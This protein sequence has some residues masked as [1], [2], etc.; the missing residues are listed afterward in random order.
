MLDLM[1]MTGLPEGAPR[2]G[3]GPWTGRRAAGKVRFSDRFERMDQPLEQGGQWRRVTGRGLGMI[4][5]SRLVFPRPAV[6]LMLSVRGAVIGA[7]QFIEVR[8]G[9]MGGANSHLTLHVR[10]SGLGANYYRAFFC[11]DGSCGLDARIEGANS[12]LGGMRDCRL[13]AGD[14]VR[15]EVREDCLQ[16]RINGLLHHRRIDGRL[17]AGRPGLGAHGARGMSGLALCGVTA[18]DVA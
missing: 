16:V 14:I 18:G 1:Q 5:Q 11:G 15:F 3:V 9:A 7:D 8:L 6:N 17:L 2:R 10:E 4:R 13:G 12:Y